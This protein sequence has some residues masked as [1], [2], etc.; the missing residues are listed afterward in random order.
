MFCT[1]SEQGGKIATTGR[2]ATTEELD[3][4]KPYET[5]EGIEMRVIRINGGKSNWTL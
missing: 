3:K 2:M 5:Q 4:M 1:G